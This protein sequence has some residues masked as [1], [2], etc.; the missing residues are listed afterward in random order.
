MSCINWRSLMSL[1]EWSSKVLIQQ[2]LI[3]NIMKLSNSLQPEM[4]PNFTQLALTSNKNRNQL[5]NIS[6]WWTI[7][8]YVGLEF[9]LTTLEPCIPCHCVLMLE[10]R[11]ILAAS[12]LIGSTQHTDRTHINTIPSYWNYYDQLQTFLS[13][14]NLSNITS[15]LL[16]HWIF[17]F[18]TFNLVW[19][20][21][22]INRIEFSF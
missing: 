17:T 3:S 8:G 10:Y 12:W 14:Q 4:S 5:S 11:I 7:V 16:P 6:N 15:P 9:I 21:W 13:K 20:E 19:F 1:T 22:N 2:I 18:H